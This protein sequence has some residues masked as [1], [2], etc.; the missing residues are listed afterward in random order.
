MPQ[1]AGC[2]LQ[3]HYTGTPAAAQSSAYSSTA[4]PKVFSVLLIDS[5]AFL[6]DLTVLATGLQLG[7]FIFISVAGRSVLSFK[8]RISLN[9]E[10]SDLEPSMQEQN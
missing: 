2:R 6:E 9:L 3:L 5:S 7:I 4:S 1:P 10:R 8:S